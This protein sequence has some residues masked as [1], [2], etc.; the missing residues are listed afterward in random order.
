MDFKTGKRL[1]MQGQNLRNSGLC[2]F[3]FLSF[4]ALG[5]EHER[6][7]EQRDSLQHWQKLQSGHEC[8]FFNSSPPII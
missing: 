5:C 8:F 7:N 2:G 6:H 4:F 3:V 1:L